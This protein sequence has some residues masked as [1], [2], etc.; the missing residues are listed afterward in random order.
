LIVDLETEQ[1]LSLYYAQG[2]THDFKLHK[3]HKVFLNPATKKLADSGYQGLQKVHQN[4]TTPIKKKRKVELTKEQKLFNHNLSKQRIKVENI[5]RRLKI[6]RI[7]K[8]I[9]RNRR[10]RFHLRFNLIAGIYNLEKRTGF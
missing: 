2:K 3:Q 9:Y 5:I 10:K 6:F 7:I 1:V 8:D 4:T